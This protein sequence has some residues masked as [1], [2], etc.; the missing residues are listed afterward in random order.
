MT[1]P[2]A[3]HATGSGKPIAQGTVAAA[4]TREA[5]GKW[6][7]HLR[8]RFLLAVVAITWAVILVL[9]LL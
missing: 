4:L 2:P 3:N 1:I 6:P 8:I 5:D 7:L 9:I